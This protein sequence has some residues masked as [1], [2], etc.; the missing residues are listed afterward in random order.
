MDDYIAEQRKL[1][2]GKD[3]IYFLT[4]N[5]DLIEFCKDRHEGMNN[6]QSTSKVILEM[7]MHNAQPAQVSACVLT[8]SMARCL[9]LH[10]AKVRT[11]LHEVA[12]YFNSTKEDVA[13]EVYNLFLRML[14]RRAKSVVAAV[15]KA[16]S[17]DPKEYLKILQKAIKEDQ[18]Y[19]DSIN[20]DINNINLELQEEVAKGKEEVSK[21]SDE[22]EKKS[23]EIGGAAG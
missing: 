8:E 4:T 13:P 11:K 19:Y 12:R 21:L 10:R 17:D 15:E 20:S 18:A 5:K 9:D 2:K 7:W 23:R 1:K 14:Y 16:P 22:S 6:M 3:N